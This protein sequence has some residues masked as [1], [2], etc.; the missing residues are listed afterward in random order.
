MWIDHHKTAIEE[1]EKSAMKFQAHVDSTYAACEL[2]WQWAFPGGNMPRAVWLLGKY[3]IWQLDADPDLLPMQYGMRLFAANPQDDVWKHLLD[4][5][6]RS[7]IEQIITDGRKILQYVEQFNRE[8]CKYA[9]EVTFDGLQC[10]CLNAPMRNSQVFDSVFDPERHDAML[11][12][13]NAGGKH[14]T[15]SLYTTKPDVDVGA[16]AKA[17]GGGGHRGAAG[18]QLK[19]LPQELRP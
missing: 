16:V 17:R 15:V 3:D 19:E 13:F 7:L 9:F 6:D 10:I 1:F 12:Y 2:T 14:W 18:F 5:H 11:M 4:F 8:N